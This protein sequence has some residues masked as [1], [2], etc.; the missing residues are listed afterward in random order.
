M[1]Y[2]KSSEKKSE[3]FQLDLK[4]ALAVEQFGVRAYACGLVGGVNNSNQGV[5]L[6]NTITELCCQ[7]ILTKIKDKHISDF[8]SFC[9]DQADTYLN[10]YGFGMTVDER[11]AL[12]EGCKQLMT[13][14][15]ADSWEEIDSVVNAD[16]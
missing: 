6:K 9:H 14:F 16:E 4:K 11:D 7:Y 15:G 2:Y 12:V 13:P 10:A 8:K 3:S 5:L 1:I